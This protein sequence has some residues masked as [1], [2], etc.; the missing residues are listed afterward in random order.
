MAWKK[1]KPRTNAKRYKRF[2]S[3]AIKAKSM[4][5]P[6]LGAV[7]PGGRLIPEESEDVFRY[8]NRSRP[9]DKVEHFEFLARVFN[10]DR[11]NERIYNHER[12]HLDTIAVEKPQPTKVNFNRHDALNKSRLL[13]QLAQVEFMWTGEMRRHKIHT[14]NSIYLD[15]SEYW[16]KLFFSGNH[17]VVL[18]HSLDGMYRRSIV[19]SDRDVIMRAVHNN[20]L[21]WA[22]FFDPA[23]ESAIVGPSPTISMP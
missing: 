10:I 9:D 5:G 19:Y 17:Y 11:A 16:V 20:A 4:Q 6:S 23:S 2:S 14:W 18:V 21:V 7:F 3:A 22:E 12:K 8:R 13:T 15:K 1:Q